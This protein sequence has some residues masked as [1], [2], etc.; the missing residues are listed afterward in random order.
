MDVTECTHHWEIE[1]AAGPTSPGVCQLCGLKK[2]FANY[3]K[4]SQKYPKPAK[5][6]GMG[7]M[8]KPEGGE[9]KNADKC[10]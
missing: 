6:R 1:P 7:L 8:S 5:H 4:D 3:I 10:P 2:E 9:P